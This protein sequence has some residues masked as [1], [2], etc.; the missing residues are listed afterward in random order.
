MQPIEI[1]QDYYITRLEESNLRKDIEKLIG[2]VTLLAIKV[3]NKTE[4]D[5]FVDYF[6][7]V[8]WFKVEMIHGGYD[9]FIEHSRKNIID[10]NFDRDTNR[11][12][13][14]KLKYAIK[15]LEGLL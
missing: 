3:N 14:D 11:V 12:I 6:G 10:I 9:K 1:V 13:K 15:Y 7:H 4:H 2:Q 5:V 8:K